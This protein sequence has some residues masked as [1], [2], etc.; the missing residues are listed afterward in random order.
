MIKKFIL[1]FVVSLS[2]VGCQTIQ[3][4]SDLIPLTQNCYLQPSPFWQNQEGAY[5]QKITVKFKDK[6]HT[7]SVHIS[8]D[9]EKLEARA[10]NDLCSN[11]YFLRWT[12]ET[13]SWESSEHIPDVLQPNFILAD[14]MLTHL[15]LDQLR[16]ALK[17]AHIKE[18]GDERIIEVQ[19]KV[20]RK[21]TRSNP[22]GCMWKKVMIQNT[23]FGYEITIETVPL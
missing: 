22:I 14:I 17:G 4:E 2:L 7:F 18:S 23:E 5:L 13:T 16:V 19:G 3:Q 21:I 11:L 20:I 6:V 15:T 12:P 8:F 10:F 1:C 9:K